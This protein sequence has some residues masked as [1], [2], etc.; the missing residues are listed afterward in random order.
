MLSTNSYCEYKNF[1]NGKTK[2]F[3][4]VFYKNNGEKI[5]T[6]NLNKWCLDNN[7]KY[8]NIYQM[9]KKQ[10]FACSGDYTNG[11]VK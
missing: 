9:I 11:K 6:N 10:S 5:M 4:Y 3:Q 7:V 1:N 8:K 2:R